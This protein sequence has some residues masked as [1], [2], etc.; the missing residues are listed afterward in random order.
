MHHSFLNLSRLFIHRTQRHLSS[1]SSKFAEFRH[2]LQPNK[3]KVEES[4]IIPPS[5]VEQQAQDKEILSTLLTM[6]MLVG[7]GLLGYRYFLDTTTT[8]IN[9]PSKPTTISKEEKKYLK[10]IKSEK[11][12]KEAKWK[13]ELSL[14]L[15]Q[16]AL[17][18]VE[19][20]IDNRI[21][22]GKNLKARYGDILEVLREDTGPGKQ[23]AM[24]RTKGERP[25]VGLFPTHYMG[26]RVET[27]KGWFDWMF[28]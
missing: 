5:V 26:E 17:Y 4:F 27:R 14:L 11:E 13:S 21:G 3:P 23:Y 9:S 15:K 25:Q 10:R 20:L 1:S 24:C 19:V 22:G 28:K 8:R 7:T 2:V 16:R 18:D 6:A 12:E